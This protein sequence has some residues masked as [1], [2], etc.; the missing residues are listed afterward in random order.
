M[1]DL[2]RNV[3]RDMDPREALL[4]HAKAAADEP[5]W[6]APAYAKTQ[7]KQVFIK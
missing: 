4:A 5:L 2:Y 3:Q 7:P 6:I 1:K